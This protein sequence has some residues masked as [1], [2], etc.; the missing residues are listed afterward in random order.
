MRLKTSYEGSRILGVQEPHTVD[1]RLDGRRIRLFTVGGE[2]REPAGYGAAQPTA[3]IGGNELR[4]ADDAL[5]VRLAVRAGMHDVGVSFQ[6]ETWEP[7]SLLPPELA[8]REL[9]EPGLGSMVIAG[10]YEATGPGETASRRMIF[11]CRP[12]NKSDEADKAVCAEK[13][14]SRLARRAFRRPIRDI[15]LP[16]LM[17]PFAEGREQGGFEAGIEW[18]LLRILVSPEFLFRFEADPP[19]L[20]AGT[21]Y[22]VGFVGPIGDVEMASR[23]SFFLWSS[24]PDEQLL[25]LAEAGRLS[26]PQVL[27]AEVRRMLA[28]RRAGALAEILAANGSTCA[29]C[30]R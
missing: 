16:G 28:D 21:N 22:P 29:T 30:G 2:D 12:D 3:A 17:T 1:L 8:S 14:I 18:A 27:E 11:E 25:E 10:P 7:E 4:R 5:E 19:G 13:I 23:L 6:R 20:N 9:A 26:E 15:D 24:I